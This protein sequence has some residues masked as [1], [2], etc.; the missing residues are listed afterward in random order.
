MNKKL[1]S[2]IAI[3][4]GEVKMP[5]GW[6]VNREILAKDIIARNLFEN[7]FRFSKEWDRLNKYII[8]YMNVKH[9]IILEN[10]DTWGNIYLPYEKNNLCC[11]YN[12]L[13]IPNSPDFV[14]LYGVKIE[15][16]SCFVKIRYDNNRRKD[17]VLNIDINDNFFVMFPGDL[18]YEISKNKSDKLNLIQT[19]TYEFI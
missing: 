2:E 18:K 8:E 16:D 3:Y 5:E 12:N 17:Q 7:R 11:E 15:P 6:D 10:K 13:D 14:L 4:H 9:K 1:L 19:I